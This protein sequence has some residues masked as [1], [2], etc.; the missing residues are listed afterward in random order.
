ME[1]REVVEYLVD[2]L[3]EKLKDSVV[4]KDIPISD[5]TN[6]SLSNLDAA[7]DIDI[8][9][10]RKPGMRRSV[11]YVSSGHKNP[12]LFRVSFMTAICSLLDTMLTNPNVSFTEEE[13]V[14]MFD[15][16]KYTHNIK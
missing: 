10:S 6:L 4:T 12:E 15:L 1:N 5:D 16:W 9:I 11:Q 13:I 7:Y 3:R 14:S 2:N 8:F